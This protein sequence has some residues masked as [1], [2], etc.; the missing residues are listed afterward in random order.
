MQAGQL[1]MTAV[2]AEEP[3]HKP[4]SQYKIVLMI[5]TLCAGGRDHQCHL[6]PMRNGV[7]SFQCLPPVWPCCA[8][9]RLG[10]YSLNL[11]RT[12]IPV[13][14][15]AQVRMSNVPASLYQGRTSAAEVHSG[16]QAGRKVVLE[17]EQTLR[18]A[19]ALRRDEKPAWLRASTLCCLAGVTNEFLSRGREVY[20]DGRL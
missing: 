9:H 11:R 15:E 17:S 5:L 4:L 18:R 13:A 1:V 16:E 12:Q 7:T 10:E 14:L 8:V 19:I 20:F 6:S 2:S 3:G